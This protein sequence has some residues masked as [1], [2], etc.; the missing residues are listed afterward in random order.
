MEGGHGWGAGEGALNVLGEG[1]EDQLQEGCLNRAGRCRDGVLVSIR[2]M[3]PPQRRW[4]LCR[5]D[6]Q[7]VNTEM[8]RWQP[9]WV[10]AGDRVIK[11]ETGTSQGSVQRQ[12]RF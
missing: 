12:F 2:V 6:G 1:G 4:E 9:R 8:G 5:E 11:L 10:C 7:E 3:G